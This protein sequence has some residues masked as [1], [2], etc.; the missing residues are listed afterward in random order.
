MLYPILKLNVLIFEVWEMSEDKRILVKHLFHYFNIKYSFS[1]MLLSDLKKD[2]AYQ[3]LL[4][5]CFCQT[6]FF[7]IYTIRF[8]DYIYFIVDFLINR[9]LAVSQFF[10][11]SLF[12]T[13]RNLLTLPIIIFFTWIT[14][15]ESIHYKITS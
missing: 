8:L 5:L 6:F 13:L 12:L 15:F 4:I 10:F 9:N 1:W 7:Y 11:F 14:F 2:M 3:L